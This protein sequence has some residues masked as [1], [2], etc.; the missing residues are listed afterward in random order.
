MAT[1]DVVARC[2]LLS[3][4]SCWLLLPPVGGSL[5]FIQVAMTNSCFTRFDLICSFYHYYTLF[6]VRLLH[7]GPALNVKNAY[8]ISI[9]LLSIILRFPLLFTIP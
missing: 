7:A 6:C 4:K 2:N 1:A 5:G 8:I 3:N 9:Y